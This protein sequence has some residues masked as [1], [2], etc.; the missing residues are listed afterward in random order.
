MAQSIVVEISAAGVR[1]GNHNYAP[2]ENIEPG[3]LEKMRPE[4]AG[5]LKEGESR[6]RQVGRAIQNLHLEAMRQCQTAEESP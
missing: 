6:A 1:L 4:L 2:D 5:Y 3:L